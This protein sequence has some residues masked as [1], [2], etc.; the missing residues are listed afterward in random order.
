MSPIEIFRE[1]LFPFE[2]T[3]EYEMSMRSK[4][5][6]EKVKAK[7]KARAEFERENHDLI[8]EQIRVKAAENRKT[9]LESIRYV[10]LFRVGKILP[11]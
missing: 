5:E 3:I 7:M 1:F 9:V 2:A 10:R 4:A 11:L 8:M 6:Q